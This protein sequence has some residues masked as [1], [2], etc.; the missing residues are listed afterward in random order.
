[1]YQADARRPIAGANPGA[2]SRALVFCP[3]QWPRQTENSIHTDISVFFNVS[4]SSNLLVVQGLW[5]LQMVV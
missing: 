1:M 3:E 4:I 2:F 5:R